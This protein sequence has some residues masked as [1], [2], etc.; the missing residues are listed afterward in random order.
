MES[1]NI[2]ATWR[3]LPPEIW[4]DLLALPTLSLQ[5]LAAFSQAL[6]RVPS[7]ALLQAIIKGEASRRLATMF[8]SLRGFLKFSVECREP[9]FLSRMQWRCSDNPK[10]NNLE[11]DY[12]CDPRKLKMT[13]NEDEDLTQLSYE[14]LN[15]DESSCHLF[16]EPI[17]LT[18]AKFCI[19]R[20]RI[21]GTLILIYSQRGLSIST[22][23]MEPYR[24]GFY[25]SG[26]TIRASLTLTEMQFIRQPTSDAI[27]LPKEWMDFV[28]DKIDLQ[29]GFQR[30]Y[31]QS[32]GFNSVFLLRDVTANINIAGELISVES[33][34]EQVRAQ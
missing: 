21:E 8:S 33:K 17:R 18:G 26:R 22:E 15:R 14:K 30:R 7:S 9:T 19:S 12:T 34:G 23:G 4:M 10:V 31:H 20:A 13:P 1:E 2:P 28:D 5:D 11:W 29:V 25:D 24:Y 27:K 16:E 3:S 6:N 32:I